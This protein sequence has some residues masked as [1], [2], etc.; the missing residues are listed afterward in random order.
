MGETYVDK[1][2]QEVG[3]AACV[4]AAFSIYSP[5]HCVI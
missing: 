5:R 3:G 1:E 2:Q 4:H